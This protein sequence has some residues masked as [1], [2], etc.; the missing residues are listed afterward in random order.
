MA[1]LYEQMRDVDMEDLGQLLADIES[2]EADSRRVELA[3]GSK[4]TPNEQK[5]ASLGVILARS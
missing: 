3:D 2:I 5:R 1:Q 4:V